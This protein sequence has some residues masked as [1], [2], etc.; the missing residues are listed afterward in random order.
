MDLSSRTVYLQQCATYHEQTL[1]DCFDTI[2]LPCVQNQ[3]FNS[4]KIL[5]K[6]NLITARMG[7]LACTEGKF[8]VAAAK[9]FLDKGAVVSI[10]DS[11]AF[12]T[13]ASVLSN[14][15]ISDVLHTLPITITNF[16]RV[17]N[18]CLPSGVKAGI[19]TDALDCD[20]L[21]NIPRVKAHAQLRVTLAVKNLFGCLAGMRK[22]VW[23]MIYG[24]C[25]GGFA[26]HLVELLTILPDGVTLVD[27]I[28]TMH[29]TGPITGQP[30][31]LELVAC[32]T[33]PVAV[34]R[35]M[36]AILGVKP[37]MSP[38]M[39]S[40]AIKGLVGADIDTLEYP[41]L[42]PEELSVDSFE[43]PDELHPIRFNPFR[44]VRGSIRRFLMKLKPTP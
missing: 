2:L 30:Y 37:E 23:H 29:K 19:A 32:S 35:S 16:G 5:L 40:C 41:V 4:L 14:L 31:P 33:N 28:T 12:G 15:N 39:N 22:P 21:I 13:T 1:M 26:D 10:G 42:H 38:L 20:L 8:I 27:G 3:N 34:D 11:P 25:D 24:G 17:R 43:V 44:F 6:P 9:W 18:V 36:L 7:P